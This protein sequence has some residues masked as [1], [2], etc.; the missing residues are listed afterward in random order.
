MRRPYCAI[1]ISWF[2]AAPAFAA[3]NYTIDSLHSIPVFEFRHLGVTT[4]SGRFDKVSGMV[5]LD[6]A[7][8]KG[9]VEFVVETASLNM[10]FGTETRESPG[11][12]L[13]RVDEFPT[14][15]F[16]SDRLV[17]EGDKIVAAE[18]RFTLLGVTKP[19]R[20]AVSRFRCAPHPLTKKQICAGEIAAHIM[21]SEYGM[22]EYIPEISDEI[23]ISVPIEAHKN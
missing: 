17:F 4:Q 16:K 7:N 9:S 18:G 6:F 13:F 5:T 21:R 1:A 8:K 20:I 23:R 12:L 2:L 14:I 10:G 19:L 15:S 11:Y 3:D 22:M